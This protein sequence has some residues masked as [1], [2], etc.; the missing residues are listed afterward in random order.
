MSVSTDAQ[1]IY[2]VP[3]SEKQI[4]EM[5]ESDSQAD[6]DISDYLDNK[7][8]GTPLCIE[9]HCS[10]KYP[11]YILG[12]RGYKIVAWRGDTIRIDSNVDLQVPE[13]ADETIRKNADQAGFVLESNPS[14]ILCSW[15]G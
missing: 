4:W 8:H 10:D 11:M 5:Q 13:D 12:L 7:V 1:L 9:Y 14:W 2:G 6:S 3:L 15:W